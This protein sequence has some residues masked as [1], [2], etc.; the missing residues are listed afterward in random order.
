M[1]YKYILTSERCGNEIGLFPKAN[2]SVKIK[3]LD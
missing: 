1:D 2:L 3:N